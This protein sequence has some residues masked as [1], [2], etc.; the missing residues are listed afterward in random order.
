[1]GEQKALRY[2]KI[3]SGDDTPF[4]IWLGIEQQLLPIRVTYADKGGAQFEQYLRAI[5]P[6]RS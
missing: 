5:N 2:T 1:M 4:D 3:L 6:A